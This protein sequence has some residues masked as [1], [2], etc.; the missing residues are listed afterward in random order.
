M[1]IADTL[2]RVSA[3]LLAMLQTRLALAAVEL[4][5]EGQRFLGYLVLALL[6]LVLFGIAMLL[7]ALLVIIVFWDSYRIAAVGGM[8]ALFGVAAALTAYKLKTSF[9][10]KPRLMAATV[11][12]LNKDINFIRTVGQSHEQ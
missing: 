1:A 2:G 3:G 6:S 10:T 11:G 5:E 7:V 12:E 4:E 9:A 8:A